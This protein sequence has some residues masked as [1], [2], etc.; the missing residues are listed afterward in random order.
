MY[1]QAEGWNGQG[2]HD[3]AKAP[4]EQLAAADFLNE[5]EAGNAADD[6]EHGDQEGSAVKVCA[7]GHSHGCQQVRCE[8]INRKEGMTW[9]VQ[10]METNSVRF[11]DWPLKMSRNKALCCTRE[12]TLLKIGCPRGEATGPTPCF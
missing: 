7:A 6:E 9:A 11:Q 12:P 4:Q 2:Q 5:P 8:G 3:D 1:I 10:K